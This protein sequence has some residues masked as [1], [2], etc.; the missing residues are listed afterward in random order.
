ML[1]ELWQDVPNSDS[2]QNDSD[3]TL[4]R[5]F[6]Y[7]RHFFWIIHLITHFSPSLVFVDTIQTDCIFPSVVPEPFENQE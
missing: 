2:F 4:P 7:L 1:L 6:Q 3:K 5:K